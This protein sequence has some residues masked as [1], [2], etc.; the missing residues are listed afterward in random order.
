MD[1]HCIDPPS[2]SLSAR[3][4][5]SVDEV[6]EW[7]A[8]QRTGRKT[9]SLLTPLPSEAAA[10][11]SLTA[12]LALDHLL[13][14]MSVSFKKMQNLILFYWMLLFSLLTFLLGK[15]L[16]S[17]FHILTIQDLYATASVSSTV[18]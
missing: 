10:S 4:R 15:V 13:N 16:L 17:V 8:G 6:A 18:Y 5:N 7:A 11:V 3:K 1:C 14:L 9:L 12:R 2:Q